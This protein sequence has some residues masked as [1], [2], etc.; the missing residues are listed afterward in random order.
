MVVAPG[1]DIH[2]GATLAALPLSVNVWESW[3]VRWTGPTSEPRRTPPSRAERP[4]LG[5]IARI[6]RKV[7]AHTVSIYRINQPRYSGVRLGSNGHMML[8]I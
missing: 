6:A 4:T 5:S 1:L 7:R 8:G 2:P 3:L